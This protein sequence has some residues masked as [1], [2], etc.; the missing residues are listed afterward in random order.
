MNS[1]SA[2]VDASLALAWL[3]FEEHREQ[4]DALLKDWAEDGVEL[5]APPMFHAEVT[6]AIRKNVH[7]KRILPQEEDGLFNAYSDL[8]IRIIGTPEVYQRAW[9]LAKKFD[10]PV[11]YDMQYIAVAELEDCEL[12][13][14]DKRLVT[15]LHGKTKR[16]K[17]VGDFKKRR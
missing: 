5:V 6:S 7:F 2:C 13:T 8:P 14:L 15:S 4:A 1:S 9:E 17:W 10:L 12:W 3:F 16:V 11:C